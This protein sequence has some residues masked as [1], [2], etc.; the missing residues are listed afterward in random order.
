MSSNKAPAGFE[1][2][3][4]VTHAQLAQICNDGI[5]GA[6]DKMMRNLRGLYNQQEQHYQ[7]KI[8]KRAADEKAKIERQEEELR[9]YCSEIESA[10]KEVAD[11]LEAGLMDPKAGE[12]SLRRLFRGLRAARDDLA[13]LQKAEAENNA[14]LDKTPAQYEAEMAQR[15]PALF[16]DGRGYAQITQSLLEGN[17]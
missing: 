4:A 8:D 5:P 3:T 15:F 14:F 2:S 9:A 16:Q 1:P 11:D 13:R 7:S 17:G 6:T 12:E 10:A